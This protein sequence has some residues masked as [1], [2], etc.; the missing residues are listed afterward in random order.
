MQMIPS[1]L[2]RGQGARAASSRTAGRT[3]VRPVSAIQASMLA[4]ASG[5][6]S[7]GWKVR[8]GN[9]L[10]EMRDMF[11]RAAGD[12]EHEPAQRQDFPQDVENGVAI[13]RDCGKEKAGIGHPPS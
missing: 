2:D 10:G 12:F 3:L 6:G 4:R 5:L 11:A 7:E 1:A 9:A 13:A 8:P